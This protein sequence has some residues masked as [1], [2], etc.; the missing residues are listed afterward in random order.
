PVSQAELLNMSNK[1]IAK[2]LRE[3]VESK[4]ESITTVY[5][6]GQ[7]IRE[8]SRENPAKMVEGLKQFINTDYY[9][10]HQ[11]ILG[12]CDVWKEQKT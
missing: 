12:L 10:I 8:L 9:Y 3:Y 7:A 4:H 5:S 11:I 2:Y 1:E 6:L